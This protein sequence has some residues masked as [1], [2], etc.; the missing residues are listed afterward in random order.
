MK[1]IV[2]VPKQIH[3]RIT[4]NIGRFE[5]STS[6]SLQASSGARALGRLTSGE[7]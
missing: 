5:V 6:V 1:Q 4:E 3:T 7:G 2:V